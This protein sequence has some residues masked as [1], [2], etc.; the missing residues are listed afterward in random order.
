MKIDV[1]N[2]FL[3]SMKRSTGTEV[4][5]FQ[6][7]TNSIYFIVR[8]TFLIFLLFLL[9]GH[10]TANPRVGTTNIEFYSVAFRNAIRN[11]NNTGEGELYDIEDE[12]RHF[13]S[14]R[15]YTPAWTINFTIKSTYR[16]LEELLA[17]AY[18][19]GL[20]PSTYNFKQLKELEQMINATE[21]EKNKL[22]LRIKFEQTA[23]KALLQFSR[24]IAIGFNTDDTSSTYLS[25]IEYLPGYLNNHLIEGTLRDGIL[26]LQPDNEPYRKL[27][28]AMAR[29]IHA[30]IS[31]TMVCIPDI[32]R[33]DWD[34]QVTRL[35]KQGYLDQNFADDTFAVHSAVR[36]FQRMHG[37]EITGQ[38]DQE[39][40]RMLSKNTKEKFLT[41]ALNLDRLRKDELRSTDYVLV[42]IPEF[43]LHYYN[44]KG[45]YTG[46]NV[47]V[48]RENTPTPQLISQIESIVT[49]PQWT[50]PQSITRNEIIPLIKKD[51]LYLQKHGFAVVDKESNPVDMS[52]INWA[53]LN[54]R[55]F[56]Y[57]FRQT[58]T[59]NA[60]GVVKFL[61]PNTNAVYLHD[62][63]AKGLFTG[64]KR[65]HSH[66]CIRLENPVEFAKI[67]VSSYTYNE[68]KVDIESIIRRKD[69]RQIKLDKPLPIYL[70]YYSCLADSTGNIHYF[71]DIY[72]LDEA[73]IQQLFAN[74]SW[75]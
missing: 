27:Q 7:I 17:D 6:Q 61:F 57:W 30:A 20:F 68:N 28:L 18:S 12:V 5:L 53:D 45:S 1:A 35:V 75:D 73:A 26:N 48:G 3:G 50:V 8:Y 47:I 23:T 63:Q 24:H 44:S 40:A 74:M 69:R 72:N 58:K 43:R 19:Y 60:L 49:N 9:A 29:Y 34:L 32:I 13:Y 4:T 67:L 71:P 70:R 25:F 64:R 39:T 36:N 15:Q 2:G 62:T 21:G 46:F 11:Q 38:V 42:N 55:E 33:S 54:P 41:I 37:L 16:E 66:G 56:E 22:N 14:L 52:S 59:D 51:S 31:D 65:A 10:E